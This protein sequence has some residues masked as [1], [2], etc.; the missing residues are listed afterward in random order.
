MFD[1]WVGSISFVWVPRMLCT[2]VERMVCTYILTP[3]HEALQDTW[4]AQQQ[5]SRPYSA[6]MHSAPFKLHSSCTRGSPRPRADVVLGSKIKGEAV[7]SEADRKVGI[8]QKLLVPVLTT[9]VYNGTLPSL[10]SELCRT[11]ISCAHAGHVAPCLCHQSH[12][13]RGSRN[14]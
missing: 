6:E 10:C 3:L 2:A 8:P 12:P 11:P 9:R 1:S 7:V 5:N 4:V 13:A 14:D